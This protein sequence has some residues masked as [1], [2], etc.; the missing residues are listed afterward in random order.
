MK[1]TLLIVLLF[2]TTQIFAQ[3]SR[4]KLLNEIKQEKQNEHI[5][6]L[7]DVADALLDAESHTYPFNIVNKKIV[8][9]D[10]DPCSCSM[11]ISEEADDKSNLKSRNVIY[12]FHL[13]D[14]KDSKL[15]KI[16]KGNIITMTFW[17]EDSVQVD[18]IRNEEVLKSL[19]S[20]EIDIAAPDLYSNEINELLIEAAETCSIR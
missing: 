8:Y 12:S 2:T 17:D 1:A 11:L 16:K 15:K 10:A 7:V 18:V 14:L 6:M 9:D 5:D 19:K 4:D 20:N 3:G 13:G